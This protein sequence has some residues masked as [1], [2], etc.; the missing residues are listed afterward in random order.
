MANDNINV[1][2]AR[3]MGWTEFRSK[4]RTVEIR[5]PNGEIET[6]T[7]ARCEHEPMDAVAE[8]AWQSVV[9]GYF[10]DGTLVGEM[11]EWAAGRD[12][13]PLI[14]DLATESAPRWLCRI[15]G[16]GKKQRGDSPQEALALAIAS[17]PEVKGGTDGS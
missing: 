11:L 7:H 1:V 12:L 6:A 13:W 15:R 10:Y 9:P 3:R 8:R 4:H 5:R 2:V 17:L 14:E 16:A